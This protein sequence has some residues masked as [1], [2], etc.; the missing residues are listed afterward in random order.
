M[1]SL[2][3]TVAAVTVALTL[4][5]AAAGHARR[6]VV[7]AAALRA[8]AV[9]PARLAG[10]VAMAVAGVEAVLGIAIALGILGPSG[11]V[12][13]LDGGLGVL[14]GPAVLVGPALAAAGCLFAAYAGYTA[15]V[16]RAGAAGVPCG[17][18]GSDV[19]LTGWVVGR[20]AALVAVALLGFVLA[21]SVL[22]IGWRAEVAIALCAAGTFASLL[23][24]LP[25]AMVVGRP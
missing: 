14:G 4:L 5:A 9:L 16:L 20:A 18:G 8:H 6:P 25:A 11:L 2:V 13:G 3:A 12:G 23:A 15:Y 17:C 10:P 19:E 24:Q 1:V 22:A 7:L 21:P